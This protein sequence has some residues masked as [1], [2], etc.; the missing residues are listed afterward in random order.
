MSSGEVRFVGVHI[1]A[2]SVHVAVTDADARVLARSST[3]VDGRRGPRAVLGEA[4]DLLAKLRSEGWAAEVAGV[5]VGIPGE[6]RWE[7]VRGVRAAPAW[8][9]L[10]V[11]EMVSGAV[12][13]PVVVDGEVNVMARGEAV[14]GTARSVDDFLFLKVGTHIG[15]AVVI[16]GEVHRG[17]HGSAGGIGHMRLD[18]RGPSCSIG[19][20]GCLEA[21][22]GGDA[23][24]RQAR[25]AARSDRSP[26]LAER[27]SVTGRLSAQDL[28]A[29]AD[30][31]DP[32]ALA[33]VREGGR[34]IGE[35]LA[36][37]VS[38]LNPGLVVVG[39]GVSGLGHRLLAEVREVVHRASPSSAGAVPVVL[40]EMG[41]AAGV[42]GAARLAADW[43]SRHYAVGG[44]VVR[45]GPAGG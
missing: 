11:V 33:L 40:S 13:A 23:L 3:A 27:L 17:V 28:A 45:I 43:H 10:P 15:C 12:Q 24:A 14:A 22:A 20:V 4:L 2:T 8:N 18:S 32:A 25:A 1:G 21:F 5:G 9:R 19:H 35:A 44:N 26:Y 29:A 6:A 39:G 16:D 34:R 7:Q 30:A 42:V 41:T 38:L 37:V 31:G 36:T